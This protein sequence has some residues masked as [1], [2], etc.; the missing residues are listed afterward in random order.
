MLDASTHI[1]LI[2]IARQ[3]DKCFKHELT[4][5]HLA[6]LYSVQCNL[7]IMGIENE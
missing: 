7:N 2:S 4:L 1:S 3:S 6:N 5:K